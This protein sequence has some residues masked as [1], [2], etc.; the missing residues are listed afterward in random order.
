[1]SAGAGPSEPGL[2]Y[3]PAR[4]PPLPGVQQNQTAS[5]IPTDHEQHV[6]NL[7]ASQAVIDGGYRKTAL[8]LSGGGARAAYQGGALKAIAEMLPKGEPNPSPILCGTSAGAINAIALATHVGRFRL[9]ATGMEA[10]WRDFTADAVYR[11]EFLGLLRRG[12]RWLSALFM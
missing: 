8:I 11:T 7:S 6:T 10:V 12:I 3:P 2:S 4:L 5:T 1:G 9:G